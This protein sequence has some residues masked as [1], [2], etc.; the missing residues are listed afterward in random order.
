MSKTAEKARSFSKRTIILFVVLSALAAWVIQCSLTETDADEL[1]NDLKLISEGNPPTNFISNYDYICFILSDQPQNELIAES[2]RIGFAGFPVN[3]AIYDSSS[4]IVGFVK[5]N[6]MECAQI[7]FSFWIE[8]E[9]KGPRC[10]R[11]DKLH[12][13]K[14]TSAPLSEGIGSRRP[15]DPR[16]TNYQITEKQ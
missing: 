15:F 2:A 10:F 13:V 16:A 14:L 3:C 1:L 4:V 6:K 8:E 12:V 5:N 9:E 11:T 7:K